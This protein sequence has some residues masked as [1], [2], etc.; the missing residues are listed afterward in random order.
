MTFRRPRAPRITGE[1][2]PLAASALR[3]HVAEPGA[4]WYLAPGVRGARGPRRACTQRRCDM[5]PERPGSCDPKVPYG[6][7]RNA[8]RAVR[9]LREVKD[10]RGLHV[11][12]CAYCRS[13]FHVGHADPDRMARTKGS[14]P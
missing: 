4:G 2:L 11:Y 9:A 6:S 13:A 3:R 1:S 8:T 7:W 14:T 10:E 12:H 5:G